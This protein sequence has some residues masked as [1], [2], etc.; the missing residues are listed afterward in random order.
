LIN[1]KVSRNSCRELEWAEK[2]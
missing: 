2:S 1:K